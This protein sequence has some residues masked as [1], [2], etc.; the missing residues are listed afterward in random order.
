MQPRLKYPIGMQ[1]FSA[2]RREGCVYVDKTRFIY[3]LL[4]TAK[5]LFLGRPRRFGKS[6]FLST[7][8][9]YF[10]GEKELFEGLDIYDEE[11]EWKSYPVIHLDLSIVSTD[12]GITLNRKMLNL[13]RELARSYGVECPLEGSLD[14]AFTTLISRLKE[15]YG[16]GVVILID[17]YD[18]PIHGLDNSSASYKEKCDTL[19][20]L[21]MQ[22]KSNDANIKLCFVTGV[23]RFN[24]MSL[25]SGPNNFTDISLDK[26]FADLCGFTH[27][28]LSEYLSE[29]IDNFAASE[30][31]EQDTI[32]HKLE[33]HYNGYRF[34]KSETK[35]FSPLSVLEALRKCEFG[36]YWINTGLTS[37]FIS[38][39]TKPDFLLPDLTD[40]WVSEDDLNRI[41]DPHDPVSLMFQTGYLTISEY[42]NGRYRMAIPNMEVMNSLTNNLLPNFLEEKDCGH[43][44]VSNALWKLS[45]AI[46]EGNVNEMI[47][48]IASVLESISY[49]MFPK[50]GKSA[51]Q[52]EN[53][54]HTVVYLIFML[55][56]SN[57]MCEMGSA[58]GR[59]DMVA[60]TEKYAYI[61][62]FK[63]DSAPDGTVEDAIRQI[64]E[65]GY[66][67]K[68]TITGKRVFKIG[69]IFSNTTRSI[70]H[71]GYSIET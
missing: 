21:F 60:W 23:A 32:M 40:K 17:E 69:M 71:W 27:S 55:M 29:G 30:R 15:K 22:C 51:A 47:N 46:E 41:Y 13:L 12:D 26:D 16:L 53:Y 28:E 6:L 54:Y 24:Q 65:R 14:G 48:I 3:T 44:K 57:V 8:E 59:A 37:V 4:S 33:A 38:E 52:T 25:F 45:V 67:Q 56:K 11:H 39:L 49:H 70:S 62:E 61:F 43:R 2:I 18:V 50:E 66:E 58:H 63:M 1:S 36:N 42:K 35:V 5:Y 10:R 9:S 31:V 19:R 64:S 20:T 68:F 34:T 7:L